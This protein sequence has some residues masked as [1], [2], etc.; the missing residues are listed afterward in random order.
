MHRVIQR[1]VPIAVHPMTQTMKIVHRVAV[2]SQLTYLGF[3]PNAVEVI[4]LM[5]Y[6]VRLVVPGLY[7]AK[8]ATN[9]NK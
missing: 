7:K 9:F 8:F 6:F 1:S 5:H 2:R 3:A 4:L